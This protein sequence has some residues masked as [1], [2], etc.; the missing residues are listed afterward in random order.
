[1]KSFC[2]IVLPAEAG[3]TFLKKCDVKSKLQ[4]EKLGRGSLKFAFLMHIRN[5]VRGDKF[6]APRSAGAIVF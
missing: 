5:K 1:M 6:F 4:H 3:T 2:K